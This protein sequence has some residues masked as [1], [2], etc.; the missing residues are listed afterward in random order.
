[1]AVQIMRRVLLIDC[2]DEDFSRSIGDAI[3]SLGF[4]ADLTSS[5]GLALQKLRTNLPMYDFALVIGKAS[6]DADLRMVR[7][8]VHACHRFGHG[9]APCF[10][11]AS[12]STGDP[13]VRLQIEQLGVRYVRL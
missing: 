8:L 11:F 7:E 3:C 12:R 1:M 4:D 9:S 13:R 5:P 10:L 6:T 2:D